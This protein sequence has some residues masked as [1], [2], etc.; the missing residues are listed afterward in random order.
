[1]PKN[2]ENTIAI[3]LL[4]SS[5]QKLSTDLAA[6]TPQALGNFALAWLAFCEDYDL[7]SNFLWPGGGSPKTSST[8]HLA[9]ASEQLLGTVMSLSHAITPEER[10]G[11]AAQAV[12]E[13]ADLCL[14]CGIAPL[15]S[16]QIARQP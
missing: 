7:N 1:M 4:K 2:S 13:W 8:T 16:L 12:H 14:C 15:A 10:A 11:L 5:A 9:L 6:I 3:Q